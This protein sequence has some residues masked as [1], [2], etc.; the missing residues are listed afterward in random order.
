MSYN[1]RTNKNEDPAFS[2]LLGKVLT[3][4]VINADK[5]EVTFYC[6]TGE[7]YKLSHHQDCCESVTVE[8]ICGELNDLLDSPITQAEENSNS[9]PIADRPADDSFTWTFYR[10]STARGQVVI[11]WLGQSN[12]YYSESVSFERVAQ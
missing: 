3:A 4:I 9:D 8:D 7:I 2:D 1:Y 11:R 6:K 5:D 10:L 12:G